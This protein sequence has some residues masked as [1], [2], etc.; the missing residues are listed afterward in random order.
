[1]KK[2]AAIIVLC[3]LNF[4]VIFG[5]GLFSGC[6]SVSKTKN[7][8]VTRSDMKKE[9]DSAGAVALKKN[10]EKSSDSLGTTSKNSLDKSKEKS[11]SNEAAVIQSY[12][13]KVQD[14][15]EVSVEE[16]DKDGNLIKKTV[17]KGDGEVKTSTGSTIKNETK[18]KE[19]EQKNTESTSSEVNKNESIKVDSVA[20]GNV[21]KKESG[22]DF[23]RSTDLVVERKGFSFLDYAFW[24][25]LVIVVVILFYLNKRFKWVAG[26]VK[27][28][29]NR[30]EA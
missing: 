22:S 26:I 4:L 29:K 12:E 7:K 1:M 30:N 23:K 3:F 11:I 27:F 24:I 6:S 15:K 2:F 21:K 17:F 5:A 14:G 20:S 8:E 16:Y 10:V 25:I 19:T 28:L 9:S 13:A 18:T